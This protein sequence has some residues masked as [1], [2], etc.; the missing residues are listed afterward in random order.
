MT[1]V[2]SSHISF[3]TMSPVV[4]GASR[5]RSSILRRSAHSSSGDLKV[6]E[7]ITWHWDEWGDFPVTVK[8]MVPNKLIELTIDSKKWRLDAHGHVPEGVHRARH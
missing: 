1:V 4:I 6:G 2:L 3:L 5:K 7:I 8:K